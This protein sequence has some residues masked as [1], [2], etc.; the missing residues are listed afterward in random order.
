VVEVIFDVRIM[1]MP[2]NGR[3]TTRDA[4]VRFVSRMQDDR[5]DDP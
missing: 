3:M 2:V 1:V 5:W 4:M